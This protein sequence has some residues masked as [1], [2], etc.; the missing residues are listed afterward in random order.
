MCVIH[1]V[2]V[3]LHHA[4]GICRVLLPP[5]LKSD[6]HP[7]CSSAAT[8]ARTRRSAA[9]CAGR[10][11]CPCPDIPRRRRSDNCSSSRCASPSSALI[12]LA[13]MAAAGFVAMQRVEAHQF[14]EFEE[15]RDAPGIFERLIHAIAC[16][17]ARYVLPELLAQ[18][19]NAADAPSSSPR[20]CGPCRSCP[21]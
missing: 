2:H 17:R 16:R 21:T 8:G 14:A 5:D 19:R 3:V 11:R 6:S 1:V 12:F 4:S 15:I 20:R 7:T 9:L 10:A 18:F 13:E